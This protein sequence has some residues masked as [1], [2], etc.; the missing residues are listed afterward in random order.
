MEATMAYFR[1]IEGMEE[2]FPAEDLYHLIDDDDGEQ[3]L[4]RL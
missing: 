4:T 1:V 3:S 2:K